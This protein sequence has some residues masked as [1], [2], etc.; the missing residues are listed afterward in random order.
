MAD[1]PNPI[2]SIFETAAEPP[3]A[4]AES[5]PG[6]QPETPNAPQAEAAKPAPPPPSRGPDGARLHFTSI[7]PQAWEHPADAAA[8]ASLRRLPGFDSFLRKFL[9]A[10]GERR[11]RYLYLASAVRVTDRQFASLHRTLLACCDV[12]DVKQIP[13]LYVSQSPI[14]NAGAVGLDDPFI[15]LHSA[16]L[17]NFDEEEL[18]F[19]IGHEL[20]HIASQHVLYKTMLHLMLSLTVGRFGLPMVALLGLVAALKEWDRKS[21]LSSDRAGL[22]CVQDAATAY[23]A[24]MKT[25]GGPRTADMDTDEF[26]R[27]AEEYERGGDLRD[28][29]LKLLNLLGQTHPFP[30]LRLAELR[31]FVDAGDY[32]NILRGEYPRRGEVEDRPLRDQFAAGA[33]A[34]KSR[35]NEAEDPLLK[36]L[37][38]LGSSVSEAGAAVWDQVRGVFNRKSE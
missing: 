3:K 2:R 19:V 25:A 14:V 29:A 26:A 5:T 8:L 35:L 23:R 33:D 4:A 6:P 12:L 17:E 1:K 27:Q 34:Y 15:V 38:E 16:A 22:L 9:S 10:I 24:L 13:E 28:G 31:R 20:G 7:A 37:N 18:A 21:E 30:V 11:L 32:A 36:L